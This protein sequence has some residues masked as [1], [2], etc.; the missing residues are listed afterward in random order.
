MRFVL[1]EE[2]FTSVTIYLS[3][4]VD[5]LQ[6]IEDEHTIYPPISRQ[7]LHRARSR[8]L[9]ENLEV[10]DL[11]SGV[12]QANSSLEVGEKRENSGVRPSEVAGTSD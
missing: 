9:P 7:N 8:A 10:E 2:R 5:H 12:S 4:V 6:G 11:L 1:K 3:K